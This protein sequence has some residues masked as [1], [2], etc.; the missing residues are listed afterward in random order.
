MSAGF[1]FPAAITHRETTGVLVA[2]NQ[3]RLLAFSA[4]CETSQEIRG[5]RWTA[6][7]KG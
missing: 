4:S 2:R 5:L 6:A 1:V 3:L 7:E